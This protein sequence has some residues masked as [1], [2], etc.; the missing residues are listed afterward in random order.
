MALAAASRGVRLN[1]TAMIPLT[2]E[3][4]K[5]VLVSFLN[6]SEWSV[7]RNPLSVTSRSATA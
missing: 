3:T 4:A 6:N 1:D 5:R 7:T 2:D